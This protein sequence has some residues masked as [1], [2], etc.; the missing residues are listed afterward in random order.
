MDSSKIF[1]RPIIVLSDYLNSEKVRYDGKTIS[2]D[3]VR[4]LK[5]FAD[6]ISVCPETGIGLGVPRPPLRIYQTGKN[7]YG[8]FQINSK[9]D[10]KK[11]MDDFSKKRF[12]KN[13]K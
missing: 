7:R 11:K 6:F 10:F 1:P 2:D 9:I 5:D 4:K 8:L 3:L 12:L 13:I